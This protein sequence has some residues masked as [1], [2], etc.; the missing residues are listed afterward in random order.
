MSLSTGLIEFL[1]YLSAAHTVLFSLDLAGGEKI[2][3][4]ITPGARYVKGHQQF[5]LRAAAIGL[6]D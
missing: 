1:P 4:L 2:A 5:R 3:H 6:Y